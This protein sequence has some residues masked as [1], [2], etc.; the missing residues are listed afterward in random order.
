MRVLTQVCRDSHGF[1]DHSRGTRPRPRWCCDPSISRGILRREAGGNQQV[2]D[3]YFGTPRGSNVALNQAPTYGMCCAFH[4]LI[5][6]ALYKSA[7][8]AS[9]C[10]LHTK[11]RR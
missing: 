8:G 1:A 9:T 5:R 11:K 6:V 7:A 3:P 2:D 4:L 10:A